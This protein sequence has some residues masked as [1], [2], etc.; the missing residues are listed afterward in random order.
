VVEVVE[1]TTMVH[2]KARLNPWNDPDFVRA[3]EQARDEVEASG[4]CPD[5]PQAAAKV[6]HLLRERGYVSAR[7][8][9]ER[10]VEEALEHVSHWTVT[11]DG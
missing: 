5:G 10:T 11:R 9:V 4:C 1:M 3:F 7:V 6:Q 2:V 8:E